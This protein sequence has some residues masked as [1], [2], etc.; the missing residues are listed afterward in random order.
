LD[1]DASLITGVLIVV[2]SELDGIFL[3]RRDEFEVGLDSGLIGLG[4]GEGERD[5]GDVHGELF[6]ECDVLL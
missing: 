2:G 1:F 4:A 5:C 6:F 3:E